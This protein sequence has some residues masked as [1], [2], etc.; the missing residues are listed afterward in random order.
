VKDV[1]RA[2]KDL[3]LEEIITVVGPATVGNWRVQMGG[4]LIEQGEPRSLYWQIAAIGPS[5]ILRQEDVKAAEP[6]P[7]GEEAERCR[8][9][10]RTLE[11]KAGA[12]RN[13]HSCNDTCRVDD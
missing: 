3:T 4:S 9:C 6:A 13:R 12:G 1:L 7:A 8:S 2:Y 5:S 11:I 10:G